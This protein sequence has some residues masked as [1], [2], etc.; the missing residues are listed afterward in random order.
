[1]FDGQVLLTELPPGYLSP[2]AA[3]EVYLFPDKS[4]IMPLE[5]I[6][7]LQREE[8]SPTAR[9]PSFLSS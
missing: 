5:C 1:M 3:N 6:N 8:M 9:K 2:I 4:Q 7:D